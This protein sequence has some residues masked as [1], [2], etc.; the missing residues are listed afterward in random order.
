MKQS[1]IVLLAVMLTACAANDEQTAAEKQMEVVE[2]ADAIEDY[3]KTGELEEVSEARTHTQ[4]NHTIL[5]ENYIILSD[6][7][8]DYLVTFARRCRELYDPS[9][10]RADVRHDMNRIRAKFDTYRGC[11]ISTIH[12]LTEGQ[13]MELL[14]LG[15]AP[16]EK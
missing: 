7:R 1:L 11:R 10:P 5:N 12:A 13:K 15:K 3:I 6:R 8:N 2:D 9:P 14:D 4:L 16:G